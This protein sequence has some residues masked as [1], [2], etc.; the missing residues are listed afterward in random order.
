MY[1]VYVYNNNNKIKHCIENSLHST[2]YM[3][4]ML[5]IYFYILNYYS[6][7]S[8]ALYLIFTCNKLIRMYIVQCTCTWYVYAF[9]F[10]YAYKRAAICKLLVGSTFPSS[11][12]VFEFKSCALDE[13]FTMGNNSTRHRYWITHRIQLIGKRCEWECCDEMTARLI[14]LRILI[15]SAVNSPLLHTTKTHEKFCINRYANDFWWR[16]DWWCWVFGV[17][18]VDCWLRRSTVADIY[19]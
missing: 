14:L 16:F 3:L 15:A 6:D 18:G 10:Q 1:I 13:D 12:T 17:F 7:E 11:S 8:I 19:H 4:N 9:H 2:V 5:C